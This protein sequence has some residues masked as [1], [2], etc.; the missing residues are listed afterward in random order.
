[1]EDDEIKFDLSTGYLGYRTKEDETMLAEA[2]G[3]DR[4]LV[5]GSRNVLIS[6]AGNKVVS[7]YGYSLFG[8]EN[9]DREPI[10]SQHTWLNSTGSE[11]VLREGNG[12]LEFYSEES[13]AWETLMTGLSATYAVRFAEIWSATELIDELLFVNHDANLYEWSGGMGTFA[14]DTATTIVINEVIGTSRFLTAGTR[15]IRVKDSGGT[16]R[17]FA[18][19]GQ[20]GSTFTGVTPDPTA[21]TFD[22]NA[23]V[24]QV[25]RTNTNLISSAFLCNSIEVLDNQLYVG[26]DA[27]RDHYIS[28]NTS[29]TDFSYSSP[30]VPGEGAKLTLDDVNIGYKIGRNENG[31]ETMNVFCGKDFVYRTE[32][33]LSSGSASDREV[34]KV[35][36]LVAASNQGARSQEMIG[37]IK[38][39]IVF[40][41][42]DNE[43]VE[44]GQ[45]ENV[46]KQVSVPVSDPIKSDFLSADFDAGGHVFLSENQLLV[47]SRS[48]G[49]I[50]IL[51]LEQKFWQPPQ[52]IPVGLFS[53]YGNTLIG[54]SSAIR[55][56]YT[57]FDTLSDRKITDEEGQPFTAIARFAYR[58]HGARARMKNFDRYY[59]EMYLTSNLELTHTLRYDYGGS[60]GISE[61][62]MNGAEGDF[63]FTP[64]L[65]ASLGAHSLGTVPLARDLTDPPT[66][67]KYRRLKPVQPVDYFEFQSEYRADILDSQFQIAA[68]G[69]NAQL[70]QNS[71]VRYTK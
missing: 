10:K 51:D 7:R 48:D 42:W 35:K 5:S 14:S 32:F 52:D 21:F 9:T 2:L 41:N 66:F 61:K 16:W 44:L 8:A 67:L 43:L 38:N 46:E 31:V 36:P 53:N 23:L 60:R 71:P 3:S 59:H 27:Y 20:S 69:P 13:D 26:S 62:L 11:V 63:L 6:A 40:V 15:S 50:F 55:E 45:V 49:V 30:R 22:A 4:Y 12:E 25:V 65:N 29:F 57:L 47:S 54:H 56:S 34:V 17:E 39:G 24:V 68:H 64:A 37:K 33:I 28:K 19:T 58:N 18:Y 70:A 1:M